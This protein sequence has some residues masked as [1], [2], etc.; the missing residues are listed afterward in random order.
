M[1]KGFDQFNSI[2]EKLVAHLH[3]CKVYFP[4]N[5]LNFTAVREST[6]DYMTAKYLEDC[7]A[8]ARVQTSF[9][10]LDEIIPAG[11]CIRES[12]GLITNN[13]SRFVPHYFI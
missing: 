1:Y 7:A 4:N 9:L 10:Y 2:H 13:T 3:I 8:Q 6:E 12:S 11:M 5:V